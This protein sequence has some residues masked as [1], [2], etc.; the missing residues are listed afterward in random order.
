MLRRPLRILAAVLS[1][2]IAPAF[3]HHGWAPHF[4]GNAYV[5][6]TGIITRLELVNPHTYVYLEAL[7][8]AGEPEARWCETQS[9][10]QLERRGVGEAQFR[11]GS[12]IT[13]E[14][15]VSRQDPLGCEIGTAHFHDG[16][17][18]ALRRPDGL[19]VYGAPLAEGDRSIVGTWYPDVFLAEAGSAEDSSSAMTSAGEAAHAGFDWLTQNPTLRCSPASNIRAWAAPGLPTRIER[20]GM[21]I[22]IVHEFMDARRIIYLDATEHPE[23]APRDELGHSIG[24]F[25]DGAL[26]IE[27]ARF[28]AGALWAGR[29]HSSSLTTTEKLW[30]DAE[31][32]HLRL[33]W[34]ASDPEY[35]TETQAGSREFVRTD[36]ELARFD[37]DP[38]IGH[39]PTGRA[40]L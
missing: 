5:T 29:L 2:M 23:D 6:V 19:S 20:R 13:I 12:T 39:A 4:D 3:A 37:C 1:P 32:G 35:Y 24:R 11:V 9:R 26:L 27:T 21:Q 8:E 38:E 22:H 14:G 36:L 25:E 18:L 30:V 7:N 34:T 10:T 17:V 40:G 15:F 33:E 28:S 16:T 31:T